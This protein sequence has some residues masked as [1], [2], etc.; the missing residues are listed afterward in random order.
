MFVAGPRGLDGGPGGRAL[1]KKEPLSWTAFRRKVVQAKIGTIKK[2][3]DEVQ[4]R[5]LTRSFVMTPEDLVPE[6]LERCLQRMR[7]FLKRQSDP[8]VVSALKK[9]K[10]WSSGIP[11]NV[12]DEEQKIRNR[13]KDPLSR[14]GETRRIAHGL[15]T[16]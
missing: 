6:D 15:R 11:D 16:C 2:R 9:Y 13:V 10:N 4:P 3:M 8:L 5:D 7:D 12:A 14:D 1:E